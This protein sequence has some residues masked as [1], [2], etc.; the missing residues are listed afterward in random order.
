MGASK[1][2]RCVEMVAIQAE[3][4]GEI[5]DETS[6]KSSYV[7]YDFDNVDCYDDQM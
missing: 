4:K 6:E 1:K 5:Y 2:L 3:G 7:D